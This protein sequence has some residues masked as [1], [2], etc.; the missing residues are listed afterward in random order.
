MYGYEVQ[1]HE[2]GTAGLAWLSTHDADVV[3]VDLIMP[4][5]TGLEL[6]KK[7]RALPS[8]AKLP[9]VLLSANADKRIANQDSDSKPDRILEKPWDLKV[10]L[11][12]LTEI[13]AK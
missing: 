13:T 10:L 5:M 8:K 2:H 6:T 3:F 7:I 9:I 4:D 1:A 12:T 11:E